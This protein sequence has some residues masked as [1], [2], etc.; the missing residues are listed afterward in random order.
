MKIIVTGSNGCVGSALKNIIF[1]PTKL[2]TYK[3]L[4]GSGPKQKVK[5][6]LPYQVIG[7][8]IQKNDHWQFLT[9][10][11]CDL[12][13]RESVI[14]YF[15]NFE[16]TGKSI[17]VSIGAD[18][19]VHLAGMVPGFYNINKPSSF[20]TNVRINENVLE[21]SRLTDI[22]QGIFCLSVNMFGENLT[23]FPLN[24][25]MIMEG[26]LSGPFAGYAYSKRMLHLQCQN[27]NEQY[28]TKYYGL[29]PVNIYGPNDNFQSGR[30]IPNLI[31][32]FQE[33][34]KNNTDVVINGTGKPL[35]QFIYAPDLAKIIKNLVESYQDTKPIIC[36]S[37]EEVSIADLAQTIAEIMDFKNKIIFDDSK[38]DGVLRKTVDNSY[39]KSLMPEMSFTL[40]KNGLTEFI[41]QM[42][43]I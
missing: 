22:K 42:E 3:I 23:S 12:S 30:L 43:L 32:K 37:D 9:R 5:A 38:P 29:I 31:L 14:D 20:T 17:P 40:L 39:L 8:K 4:D 33:A 7:R 15:E 26:S 1:K 25:S 6:S 13:N 36:S 2:H 41:K 16:I 35:R 28:G 34:I 10:K 21:A 11:D 24:E 18:C 19:I 27:Y